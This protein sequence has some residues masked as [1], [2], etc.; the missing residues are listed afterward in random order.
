MKYKLLIL[1]L[2]IVSFESSL[3]AQDSINRPEKNKYNFSQLIHESGLLVIQPIKW[4]GCDWIKFGAVGIITVA[5]MQEDEKIRTYALDHPKYSKSIPM[6]I[7]N[8]WGGF[9]F[10]PLLAVTLYTTGSLAHSRKTKKIGFEIAQSML[11]SEGISF[12][13]KG[14]IG[15]SRPFRNKGA[16]DYHPFT[17]FNGPRNSFPAGH[18][19]AAFAIST[20]LS[21]NTTCGFL[22]VIAYVPA[23][24]TVASRIMQDE[25]WASDVFLGAVIGYSVGSWVVN[26][27]ENKE[28]RVQLTSLYPL[29]FKVSLD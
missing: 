12:I 2:F 3:L 4:N 15:R 25:H 17:F 29:S 27:H 22:K 24:L 23:A 10:G 28:S 11:Y 13:S 14:C 7:G 6:E 16:F 18:L 20:V 19:D 26:I 8:Q 9:F 5:L 1:L 21:K